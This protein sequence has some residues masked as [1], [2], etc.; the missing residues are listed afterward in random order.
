[1]GIC[2]LSGAGIGGIA[3]A[4]GYEAYSRKAALG[5]GVSDLT[6]LA[7][8]AQPPKTPTQLAQQLQRGRGRSS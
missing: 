3:A 5:S 1:M 6:R 7:Q 2:L 8:T 4:G